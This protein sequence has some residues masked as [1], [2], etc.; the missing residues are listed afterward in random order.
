MSTTYT[1][2]FLD[3]SEVVVTFDE[4]QISPNSNPPNAAPVTA[5]TGTWNGYTITGVNGETGGSQNDAGGLANGY[6]NSIFLNDA[7]GAG[8]SLDGIDTQG[9]LFTIDD[10][11]QSAVNLAWDGFTGNAFVW[12]TIV[13]DPNTPLTGS[14]TATLSSSTACYAAGTRILTANGEVAVEMLRAG[15]RVVTLTSF[16]LSAIR[17]I[18]HRR[19]DVARHPRSR[20]VAPI[21]ISAHA[22]APGRP[23]HDLVLSPDHSVFVDG[24]LIPVRYLVNGATVAQEKV[25]KITYY[26]VELDRHDVILAEGMAAESYLDT[27]NRCAFANGG[28]TVQA[29]PDFA[30]RVW[31]AQSCAPLVVR[32][33]VLESVRETLLTRARELGHA[34]V[35]DSALCVMADGQSLPLRREGAHLL[36]DLPRGT[37]TVRL[38]SRHMV[39]SWTLPRSIDHRRL[40]VA[41]RRVRLDGVDLPATAFGP[42]W[43]LREPELRWTDGD[44]IL[45]LDEAQRGGGVLDIALLPLLSYWDEPAQTPARRAA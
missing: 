36:A 1:Y 9:L 31:E 11:G 8:G 6:D 39:P 12:N 10:P 24:V 44:A 17:W 30:L 42:G 14:G 32:G 29:H 19:V 34:R 3:G 5:I 45:R 40:G 26:H 27:G 25:E 2:N 41:V 23:H 4:T 18:G 38:A 16:G 35:T 21:R 37:H 33:A 20:D 13:A 22:F 7:D 15:D 43:H 28:G